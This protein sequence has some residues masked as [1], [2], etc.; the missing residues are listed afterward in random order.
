MVRKQVWRS[1]TGGLGLYEREVASIGGGD[2]SDPLVD[3]LALF[4][5]NMDVKVRSKGWGRLRR[6]GR[7]RR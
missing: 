4:P 6:E 5:P 3:L 1:R 7:L 2:G